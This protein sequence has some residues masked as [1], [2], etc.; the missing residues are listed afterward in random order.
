MV[1][2]ELK[3]KF[4]PELINRID[5]KIVF[6]PL[7]EENIIKIVDLELARMIKRI[8]E[9]GYKINIDVSVKKFLAENGYDKDYG[10]RPLKRAITTHVETPIAKFLLGKKLKS[11]TVIKLK[12][13]EKQNIVVV[14]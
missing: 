14:K 11:G 1:M 7:S 5:E 10:A 4:R 13:D 2:G 12:F 6:K 3:K 9:K 8:E